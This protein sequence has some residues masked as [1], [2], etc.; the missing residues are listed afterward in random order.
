M[1]NQNVNL[2]LITEWQQPDFSNG[3]SL[4]LLITAGLVLLLPVLRRADLRLEELL[5]LGLTFWFA[6]RHERMVFLFGILAAPVVCRLLADTWEL[7]EFHRDRIL[8][9]AIAIA[10]LLPVLALAFPGNAYLQQQVDKNHPANALAFIRKS[11]LTGNML[12]DYVF[13]GYLIWAAPER[14]VFVDG[15]ADVYDPA[16]VLA[17]YANWN[18]AKV[19]PEALL[20]KY[21]IRLCLLAHDNPMIRILSLRPGW[22]SAYSDDIVTVLVRPQRRKT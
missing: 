13:G 18:A 20:D 1:L 4:G 21:D 5:F 15:R 11:G 8:P 2:Q 6:V 10:L 14:K 12:N 22:K 3:R 7:Y 17:E 16:A 9:N 19:D